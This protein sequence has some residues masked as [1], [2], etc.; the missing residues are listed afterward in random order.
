MQIDLV[1]NIL[2]GVSGGLLSLVGLIAIFVTLNTQ[3]NI[4]KAR[5]VLWKL[6]ETYQFYDYKNIEKNY[7]KINWLLVQYGKFI[8][9][10]PPIKLSINI[11]IWTIFIVG[12]AWFI[13]LLL[14]GGQFT[15]PI[16]LGFVWI[17][18]TISLV[19]LSRFIYL[20][21]KLKDISSFVNIP[22]SINMEDA[23][24]R[25]ENNFYSE[26]L[27]IAELALMDSKF[28][29]NYFN[30]E[31]SHMNLYIYSMR[32]IQYLTCNYNFS[33]DQ[34]YKKIKYYYTRKEMNI[35]KDWENEQVLKTDLSDVSLIVQLK[36]QDLSDISLENLSSITIEL[37]MKLLDGTLIKNIYIQDIT[38]EDKL[39]GI[40]DIYPFYRPMIQY[41]FSD[42]PIEM[43]EAL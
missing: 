19:I 27:S 9:L 29:L 17:L 2:F 4:E 1:T 36:K 16:L 12:I 34:G 32:N 40:V 33:T 24:H 30:N 5:E 26:S 39:T 21:V 18:V 14:M 25:L 15:N 8:K 20:L 37:E 43:K 13:F 31:P 35:P 11:G 3:Y 42:D 28:T 22:S 38:E 41:H 7:G 6:R 23:T 10:D